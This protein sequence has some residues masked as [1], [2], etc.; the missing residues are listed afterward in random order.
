MP[1]N[2]FYVDT[3]FALH[4]EVDMQEEA[5]HLKV[6]RLHKGD[7]IEL[8]NGRNQ[9]AQAVIKSAQT[10][11]IME[12]NEHTPPSPV[13]LCQAIPR[14]NRLDTIVEKGTELGMTELW[15]FPGQRS[16]KKELTANQYK[17]V[18]QITVAAMK[19]CGRLDLPSIQI[20]PPLAQWRELNFAAYYGSLAE[21]APP[22]LSV[23]QKKEGLHFFV[24]PEAGFTSEEERI[25]ETLGVRGVKLHPWILRTDTAPLAA[26]SQIY[27]AR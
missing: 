4:I 18:K 2:R 8:V 24:G 7:P 15:L 14:L 3:P 16:E 5:R 25:L 11:E 22:F 9:L 17:R 1:H 21:R 26:L 19:Q 13:I 20:K 27:A 6:M 12:L 10:A 23:L